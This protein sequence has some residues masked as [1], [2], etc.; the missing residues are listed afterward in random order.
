ML[1][2]N[3]CKIFVVRTYPFGYVA[4]VYTCKYYERPK[5]ER[6]LAFKVALCSIFFFSPTVKNWQLGSAVRGWWQ[7]WLIPISLF[8]SGLTCSVWGF[9]AVL[10][11]PVV[12]IIF[13]MLAIPADVCDCTVCLPA[14][15][16]LFSSC[17]CGSCPNLLPCL[18]VLLLVLS[19]FPPWNLH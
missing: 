19:F 7:Q 3:Y 15:S 18:P 14:T 13:L 1:Q 12:L 17:L 11:T 6:R 2:T 10:W 9:P 16:P 5:V 8:C 4:L